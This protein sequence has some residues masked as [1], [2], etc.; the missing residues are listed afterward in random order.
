M[1][2]KKTAPAFKRVRTASAFRRGKSQRKRCSRGRDRVGARRY[3]LGLVAV[4]QTTNEDVRGV[5][6]TRADNPHDRGCRRNWLAFLQSGSPPSIVLELDEASAAAPRRKAPRR[7]DS[8]E[9]RG[10]L[11]SPVAAREP[12]GDVEMALRVSDSDFV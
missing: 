11:L 10:G 3:H 4:N 8:D 2:L 7:A 5:Y 9:A 6:P 1:F 12:D